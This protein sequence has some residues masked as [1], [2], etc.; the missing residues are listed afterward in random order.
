MISNE[1]RQK[2][3]HRHHIIIVR[4]HKNAFTFTQR[5]KNTLIDG[6]VVSLT[7]FTRELGIYTGFREMCCWELG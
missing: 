3:R 7:A 1:K 4:I 2:R 5:C 6:D